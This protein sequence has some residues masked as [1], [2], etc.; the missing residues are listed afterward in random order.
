[1]NADTTAPL[2]ICCRN[3]HARLDASELE[4][5]S[6]VPCPVCGTMLRI[7]KRFDRY[8]LE[9][10]CGE[11]V[12][13][14]IYRAIDP[15]L[16]R[17]V[18][19]KILERRTEDL[20]TEELGKRFFAEAK[21]VAKLNHPGIL[22][23]YNCGVCEGKPF[24]VTRYMADGSLGH[25]VRGDDAPSLRRRLEIVAS[26]AEALRYAFQTANVVHHD[27]KPSNILL[28]PGKEVRV[29]DFDL[30]DIRQFGDL[31]TPCDSRGTPAYMSPERLYSGGEDL[32][33]DVFSLGAMLYELVTGNLPFDDSGSA[34]ELYERRREM[35]FPPLGRTVPEL[36]GPFSDLVTR[37][38]DFDPERRPG[39]GE[40]IGGIAAVSKR[41]PEF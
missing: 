20:D 35:A 16:E 37:M 6:K 21:L 34:E 33:G 36:S 40:I 31:S 12:A 39:Y 29:G 4:P 32:R 10:V 3:C 5:F 8:L 41:L 23:V 18:A 28:A 1:V 25:A 30:A 2:R 27:I 14:V 19:V 17:R 13:A 22:P 7:P 24:L 15:R 9:K 11:G 26:V 38:L